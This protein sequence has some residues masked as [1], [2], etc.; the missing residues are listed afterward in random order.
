[1][2][3]ALG[4]FYNVDDDDESDNGNE[5]QVEKQQTFIEEKITSLLVTSQLG[6]CSMTP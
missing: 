6:V 4:N 1:M 3:K 5:S 2:E